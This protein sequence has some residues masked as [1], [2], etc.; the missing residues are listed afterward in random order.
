MLSFKFNHIIFFLLC[1]LFITFFLNNLA[2]LILAILILLLITFYKKN[3]ILVATILSFLVLTRNE[4]EGLRDVITFGS[5]LLLFIIFFQKYG[6]KLQE[7]PRLPREIYYFLVLVFFTLF[8]STVLSSDV[9]VSLKASLRLTIFLLICYIL[10]SFIEN[11]KIVLLYISVLLFAEMIIGLSILYDFMRGGF[12]FFLKN[13]ILA[14][15]TGVYDNPNFVGLTTLVTTCLI[16]AL[17]FLEQ[18]N[19]TKKRILLVALLINNFGILLITDSRAAIITVLISSFIM[20]YLLN[21][22]MLLKVSLSI[23]IVFSI[24]LF[25]PII[26]DFILILLRPRE[27]SAREYLWNSGIEMFKDH[28]I[29]GVGPE[30]FPK[31]FYTYLSH[32]ALILFEE[33][34]ALSFGKI[35]SPHNYFLL[36]GAENGILGLITSISIFIVFFYLAYRTLKLAKKVDRDYYVLGVAI[37]AIGVGTFLRAFFEISGIMYYGYISRDLPFWIVFIILIFI[38][39]RVK[40]MVGSKS[41]HTSIEL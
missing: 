14:R 41:F 16:I 26:Q 25:I 15:F 19:S 1:I 13:G 2:F 36:M 34:G 5:T 20:L 18:F 27:F 40:T 32:S 30:Q 35:P 29:S 23:V 10:F 12:S 6:L 24:L 8:I 9:S 11:K 21:K 4:F 33:T 7:Y 3:F 31:F 17:F 28:Y 39:Y 38:F 37:M 22:R